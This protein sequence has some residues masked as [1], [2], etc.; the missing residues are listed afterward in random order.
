MQITILWAAKKGLH[1]VEVNVFDFNKGANAFYEGLGY[2][3][4]SRRMRKIL[5]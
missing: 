2:E 4:T 3:T 1:E 5:P